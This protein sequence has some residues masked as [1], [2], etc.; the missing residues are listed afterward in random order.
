MQTSRKQ[1][2]LAAARTIL[3]STPTSVLSPASMLMLE[4]RFKNKHYLSSNAA[5][6]TLLQQN[7]CEGAASVRSQHKR[8]VDGS[9]AG[10]PKTITRQ[11]LDTGLRPAHNT[12]SITV[13]TAAPRVSAWFGAPRVLRARERG[14]TRPVGHWPASPSGQ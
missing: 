1:S 13:R 4:G 7:F 3:S 5:L 6:L 14:P 9:E 11:L 12:A 10:D 2:L 8:R